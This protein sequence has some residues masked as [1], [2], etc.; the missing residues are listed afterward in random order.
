MNNKQWNSHMWLVNLSSSKDTYSEI[1]LKIM[2]FDWESI[3]WFQEENPTLLLFFYNNSM[4]ISIYDD[5]TNTV[6]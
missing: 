6:G 1:I 4:C 2:I 5:F 3:I